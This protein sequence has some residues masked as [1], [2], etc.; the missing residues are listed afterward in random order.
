M[1]NCCVSCASDWLCCGERFELLLHLAQRGGLG[2]LALLQAFLVSL[3]LLLERLD[4]RLDR[5][6]AL[7][8]VALGGLLKLAEGLVRPA[9]GTPARS[10]CSASALNALNASRKSASALSCAALASAAPARAS[11]RCSA[12]SFSAAA[13]LASRRGLRLLL[14]AAAAP[15]SLVQLAFAL[16]ELL[17]QFVCQPV[18]RRDRRPRASSQPMSKPSTPPTAKPINS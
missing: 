16:G 9:A 15:R 14:A 8:Q 5:F 2:G 3:Q 7:R 4:Q 17:A 18:V 6:L 12:S 10:A 11:A 13:R 1:R